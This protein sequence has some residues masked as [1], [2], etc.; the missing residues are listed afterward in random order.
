MA[1][2]AAVILS[3]WAAVLDSI[4]SQIVVQEANVGSTA[5]LPCRSND[6]HHRFQFWELEGNQ[7]FGPGNAADTAKYKFEVLTGTLYIKVRCSDLIS[8][9]TNPNARNLIFIH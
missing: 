7:L 2:S 1:A 3:V 6:D 4:V 9:I 5:V 8:C